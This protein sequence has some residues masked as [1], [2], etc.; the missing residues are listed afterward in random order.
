M[1]SR[2]TRGQII[3]LIETVRGGLV[4]QDI[5]ERAAMLDECIAALSVFYEII[6]RQKMDTASVSGS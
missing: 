1:L 5:N 3:E 2:K 4:C 6:T